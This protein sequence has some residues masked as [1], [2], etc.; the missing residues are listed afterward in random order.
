MRTTESTPQPALKDERTNSHQPDAPLRPRRQPKWIIGGALSMA[1]GALGAAWLW[2]EATD[3][4]RVVYVARPLQV[5]QVIE[6]G[7]LTT[8]SVGR[9]PQVETVPA[10]QMDALVGQQAKVALAG[11]T[12]LPDGVVGEMPLATHEAQLGLRLPSGRLPTSNIEP[13]SAVTMVALPDPA[14]VEQGQ[15][16]TTAGPDADTVPARLLTAPTRDEDGLSW[17][18]DIA[19]PAAEAPDLA[20][21]AAADRVALVLGG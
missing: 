19:V 12:L 17:L 20:R 16:V 1:M 6:A 18:V 5:G 8:V 4:Q 14:V 13:G 2:Q 10:E 15:V 3:T 9:L 21:L 7:D 11:G